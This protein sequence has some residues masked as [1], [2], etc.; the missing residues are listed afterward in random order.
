MVVGGE[1]WRLWVRGGGSRNGMGEFAG[2]G[3]VVEG[4][5]W[6]GL[7]G[8]VLSETLRRLSLRLLV[9]CWVLARG[10]VV[11]GGV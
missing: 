3:V 6:I 2:S 11:G 7:V 8:R 4:A 10:G 1:S 9:G 5:R